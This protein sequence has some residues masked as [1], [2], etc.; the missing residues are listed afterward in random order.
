MPLYDYKCMK[1]GHE[2]EVMHSVHGHGPSACPVCGGEMRKSYAPPNVVFKGSGWARKESPRGRASAKA[3][4]A[5]TGATDKPSES[6]GSGSK[7]ASSGTK[8]PD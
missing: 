1:C 2:I 5:D 4:A 8:D 7:P 3:R 6:T